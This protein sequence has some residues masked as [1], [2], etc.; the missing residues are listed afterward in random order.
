MKYNLS[1]INLFHVLVLGSLF[2]YHGK[3][4]DKTP[5]FITRV[6]GLMG[7]GILFSVHFPK[8]LKLTYWNIIN[9]T[10]FI[11]FAPFL[12]YLAYKNEKDIK[13][14]NNTYESLFILGLI[15]ILYHSYKLT[16]RYKK[17]IK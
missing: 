12:F 17:L 13:L 14:S 9:Y 2:I 3:K 15:I 10:H 11:I 8:S 7:I 1:H 16:K 4:K 5:K 6:L